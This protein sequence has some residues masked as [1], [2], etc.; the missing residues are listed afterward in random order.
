LIILRLFGSFILFFRVT[1][2]EDQNILSSFWLACTLKIQKNQT[3]N[4]KDTNSK[5]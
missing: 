4:Y 3:Q 1:N 2:F 5:K